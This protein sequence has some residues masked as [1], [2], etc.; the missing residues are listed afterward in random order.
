MCWP[1]YN[2]VRDHVGNTS[3]CSS[4]MSCHTCLV[5]D[6]SDPPHF[7]LHCTRECTPGFSV[8]AAVPGYTT[9]D[10]PATVPCAFGLAAMHAETVHTPLPRTVQTSG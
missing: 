3:P 10:S 9:L 7:S 2:H 5:C 8:A 6:I 1:C 4:Q